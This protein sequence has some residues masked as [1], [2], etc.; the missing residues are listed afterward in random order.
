MVASTGK[1]KIQT[2]TQRAGIAADQQQDIARTT[3]NQKPT[4]MQ[5]MT[6]QHFCTTI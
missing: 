5:V 3:T 2:V 6:S 1:F 4:T